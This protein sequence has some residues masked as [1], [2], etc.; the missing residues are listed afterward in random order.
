MSATSLPKGQV[1][2][3]ELMDLLNNVDAL[4]QTSTLGAQNAAQESAKSDKPK[5]GSQDQG[6]HSITHGT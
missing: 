3:Q 6:S 1:N 2:A 4:N 5:A